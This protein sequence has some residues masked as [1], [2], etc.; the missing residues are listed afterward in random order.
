LVSVN[1][2]PINPLNVIEPN[3][4]SNRA[5]SKCY[6]AL[7]LY[8]D[9]IGMRVVECGGAGDCL[10]LVFAFFMYFSTPESQAERRALADIVRGLLFGFASTPRFRLEVTS[11][12]VLTDDLLDVALQNL[13]ESGAINVD[14][15]LTIMQRYVKDSGISIKTHFAS[16]E[17]DR[18]NFPSTFGVRPADPYN[19]LEDQTSIW[20]F[21]NIAQGHWVAPVP[22]ND[23]N[24]L[25]A[26]H[27]N[28]DPLASVA[29][30]SH[31]AP[32][33][34][35]LPDAATRLAEFRPSEAVAVV[36]G[37]GVNC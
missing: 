31:E 24:D 10:F 6:R 28:P 35:T 36:G 7:E 20:N 1:L 21:G 3:P 29:A 15:V 32:H 9:S 27:M 37:E 14:G 33:V 22:L 4:N 16:H 34:P 11:E 18:L 26:Q 2:Q 17:N 23:Q 5:Y 8:A 19:Q 12:D 13:Q 30:V 25:R